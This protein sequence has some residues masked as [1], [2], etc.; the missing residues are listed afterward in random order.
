MPEC[1]TITGYAPVLGSLTD[2]TRAAF[3]IQVADLADVPHTRAWVFAP[4][5]P[6]HPLCYEAQ[7]ADMAQGAR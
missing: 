3:G 2:T 7:I 1:D 5:S 4:R 6:L